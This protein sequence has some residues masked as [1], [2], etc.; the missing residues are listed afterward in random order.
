MSIKKSISKLKKELDK[1]FS[2]YIRLRSAT[3]EGIV[4]CFTCGK[5]G[6]YKKGGMQHHKVLHNA[7]LVV[8]QIIIKNYNV[9]T[10]KVEGIM[11][12]DGMNGT[13]KYN[14]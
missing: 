13:V 5:I 9:D 3:N 8:K 14:A 1:Y 6:H 12:Q 2:L 11:Q 4:Q 10:F 7:L